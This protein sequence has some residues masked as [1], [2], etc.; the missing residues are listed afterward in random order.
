MLHRDY[1]VLFDGMEI[2]VT[3]S[4]WSVNKDNVT[5]E[6]E[7]EAGTDDVDVIRFGKETINAAAS[8]TERWAGIFENFSNQKSI[9]VKHYSPA[10][11]AYVTKVMRMDSFKQELVTNSDR[12]ESSNG[13]YYVSFDLVE[14]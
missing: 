5:N 6:R 14:Y 4:L 9:I 8:C 2:K 11:K 13:L 3:F 12:I 10:A 7:T 1:P